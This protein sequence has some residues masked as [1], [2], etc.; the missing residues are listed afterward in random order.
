LWKWKKPTK[1]KNTINF[2]KLVHDRSGEGRISFN[3]DLPAK[4]VHAEYNYKETVLLYL[5]AQIRFLIGGVP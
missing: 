3:I 2:N 5:P 1:E 4:E